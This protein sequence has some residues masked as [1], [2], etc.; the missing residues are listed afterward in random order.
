[1]SDSAYVYAKEKGIPY[2]QHT[3]IWQYLDPTWIS[4]L[5]SAAKI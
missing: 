5:G 3:F 2:K 4:D 1:M